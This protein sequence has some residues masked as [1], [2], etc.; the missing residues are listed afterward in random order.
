MNY[1]AYRGFSE[2]G[3]RLP[4]LR[5]MRLFV[6]RRRYVVN[7]WWVEK[8]RDAKGQAFKP[9][10]CVDR[11]ENEDAAGHAHKRERP[12]TTALECPGYPEP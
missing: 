10:L 9:Y 3:V 5:G 8:L 1:S 6:P 11:R 4:K 12:S 2:V 7:H